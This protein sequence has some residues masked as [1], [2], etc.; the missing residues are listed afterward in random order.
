MIMEQSEIKPSSWYTHTKIILLISIF[1]IYIGLELSLNFMLIDFYSLPVSE[2]FGE[3]AEAIK[4]LDIFGRLLSSFGLALVI[5]SFFPKINALSLK[6]NN[7]FMKQ[8]PALAF[9]RQDIVWSKIIIFILIWA[10]LFPIYRIAVDSYVHSRSNDD[11]LS[12]VRAIIYKE[13][14]LAGRI[15]ID[16]ANDYNALLEDGQR[17]GLINSLI[18]ALAYISTEFNQLI[19]RNMEQLADTYLTGHQEER[20]LKE[21]LPKLRRFDDFYR[22]EYQKYQQA[23]NRYMRAVERLED[24]DAIYREQL[25]LIDITNKELQTSWD[26][27]VYQFESARDNFK[28]LSKNP[29]LEDLH[30]QYKKQFKSSR[31]N[32]SCRQQIRAAHANDLN[33]I[34]YESGQYIGVN[35][36][37]ED[38]FFMGIIDTDDRLLAMLTTGR[39]RWLKAAYGVGEHE[40]FDTFVVSEDARKLLIKKFNQQGITL[41]DNW[42]V[43][44]V[45]A[46]AEFLYKKYE[47]EAK[48]IWDEYKTTS[49]LSIFESGL[50]RVGFATHKNVNKEAK[51]VLGSYY[52]SEFTPGLSESEYLK[53]WIAQQDNISFIRMISSTAAASAF[54]PGGSLYQL[55]VDA[56]KLSVVLPFSV[57]ISFTAIFVLMLKTLIQLC[58]FRWHGLPYIIL[59]SSLVSVVFIVPVYDSLHEE[60]SFAQIMNS[61]AENVKDETSLAIKS[62]EEELKFLVF[63][64]GLDLESGLYLKYRNHGFLQF[65]SSLVVPQFYLNNEGEKIAKI[66]STDSVFKALSSYDEI[67]NSVFYQVP[68]W[69][70][71]DFLFW[72]SDKK[73]FDANVTILKRDHSIGAFFGVNLTNNKVSKVTVPNFLENRDLALLA[74]Q[75][76]FYN[77]D[78]SSLAESF[79]NNYG[80][81]GYF[82]SMANGSIFKES[83]LNKIEKSMVTLLNDQKHLLATINNLKSMGYENLVLVQTTRSDDYQCFAVPTVSTSSF[84]ETITANNLSFKQIDNCKGVL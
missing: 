15:K 35:V 44:E 54:A 4:R 14:H 82:L 36:L 27:Y 22:Q 81:G 24:D 7:R 59:L 63:G 32:D 56:L 21:G 72:V 67:F 62:D 45:S 10:M 13:G 31:C 33:N 9:L 26:T 66:S 55:G 84:A 23:N 28:T 74:E 83:L 76:Y 73:E 58:R 64:R 53:K 3:Q 18:P 68:S 71:S 50:D 2:L 20:F 16:G 34:K 1:V 77:P 41:P 43:H 78:I 69:M 30:R 47:T 12:A 75:K 79:V 19:E 25:Q 39:K 40:T 49:K 6:L 46:I 17:A 57:A 51:R 8:F 52:I 61:F 80:D 11:K 29:S 37:P 60:N 42:Q 65:V 48:N 5:V 38:V 70:L